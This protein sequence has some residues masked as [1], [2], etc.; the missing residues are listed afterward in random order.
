MEYWGYARV[1]SEEQEADRGALRKQ[2]ERLREAGCSKIYWDIQSRT[3]EVREGLQQLIEGLEKA[4]QGT[5]VS[6]KFTR[7]DRIG[8]SS[9]L[10]YSLLTVLRSQ[11][12]KLIALDQGI[13][14]DTLGGELAIDML[15]AASK[16][17]IK[18]LQHRIKAERSHRRSQGK[19]HRTA[20]L[21]YKVEKDKYVRDCTPCVCLLNGQQTFSLVQLARHMFDTF[22][23]CGSVAA[24][25]R[26]LHADFGI[27]TKAGKWEKD[28]RITRLIADENLDE[29]SLSSPKTN[30]PMHYPWTGLRWSITGLKLMLV[31][32]IYCGGTL[33]DTYVAPKGKRKSFDNWKV[34]WE[35]H[36][37]EAI[38]T[39]AEHEDVKSIIRA[40]RN[41]RWAS[42]EPQQINPFSNLLQC[43]K[44]GA[45]LTRHA[46]RV[47][48]DGQ[49]THYYQ[50]RLY[51]AGSCSQ[52]E[53]INSR[54]LEKQV[55]NLLVL[56][57]EKLAS[58]GE[59]DI[60]TPEDSTIL[61]LRQ[62]LSQLEAIAGI[63]PILQKAKEDIRM[64]IAD[65]IAQG[66]NNSK[67]YLIAKERIVFAFSSQRYWQELE[68]QDKHALLKGCVKKITVDGKQVIMVE[69][70][71]LP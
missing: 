13:D 24:T 43:N 3:T 64:Q 71:Y 65:A 50:C 28:Q 45:S 52:G 1:S 59:E 41:N 48:K 66:S 60:T 32:P 44:C 68:P 56:E 67:Q 36:P 23:E 18:M 8:S 25:V 2:I 61:E 15:L 19:S 6:L 35:T 33:Y 51:K 47:N 14:P 54:S 22:F 11:G 12:I 17:E 31:N 16:F 26:K 57:A 10:F 9:R 49:V 53:M 27:I 55:T 21:G 46:K 34:Q 40:N 30:H 58:L 29:I 39:R 7:I 38:I 5:I 20:P 62:Q 4:P 63:N 69:L 42:N 37:D 70:L